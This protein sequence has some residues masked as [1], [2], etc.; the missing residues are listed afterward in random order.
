MVN[1]VGRKRKRTWEEDTAAHR[2]ISQHC[3]LP[4]ELSG[5]LGG[6]GWRKGE[7]GVQAH[8]VKGLQGSNL[9]AEQVLSHDRVCT[10]CADEQ[11]AGSRRA[12]FEGCCDFG[13]SVAGGAV[14]NSAELLAI[15]QHACNK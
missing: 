7:R 14:G 4:L 11:V 15:L 2:M 3:Y 9:G 6:N 10:V 8:E 1:K 12:V 5:Y 13:L